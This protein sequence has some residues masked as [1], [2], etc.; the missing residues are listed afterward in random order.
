MVD[1]EILKEKDK[2]VGDLGKILLGIIM[3]VTSILNLFGI[4]TNISTISVLLFF[5]GIGTIMWGIRK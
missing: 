5:G 2:I 1:K 4:Y 3:L